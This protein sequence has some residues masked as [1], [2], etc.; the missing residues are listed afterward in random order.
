M[1]VLHKTIKQSF[2]GL[3]KIIVNAF[4]IFWSDVKGGIKNPLMMIILAGLVILPS[5]YAWVNILASTDPYSPEA[6]GGIRFAVANMDEGGSL[7]DKEMDL[8]SQIVDNLKENDKMGWTFYETREQ[9]VQSVIQG[10]S[11]AAVVIPENFSA[12]VCTMF[13]NPVKP[14][15]EYYVNMKTNAIAPKMTN[16]AV[17]TLQKTIKEQIIGEVVKTLYDAL[18]IVGGELD[19]NSDKIRKGLNMLYDSEDIITEIPGKVS[20]LRDQAQDALDEIQD[21]KSQANELISLL[22]NAQDLIVNLTAD[23]TELDKKL[24]EYEPRILQALKDVGAI[25]DEINDISQNILNIHNKIDNV[26]NKFEKLSNLIHS[27][28]EALL[29]GNSINGILKDIRNATSEISD[30]LSDLRTDLDDELFPKLHQYLDDTYDI[31]FDALAKINDGLDE[32]DAVMDLIDKAVNKGNE[33]L[34]HVDD[35][36]TEYPKYEEKLLDIIHKVK[37]L[38]ENIDINTV[39]DLLTANSDDESNFFSSPVTVTEKD[40]YPTATYGAAMTPFYTTLCL[41]VGAVILCA[42]LTTEAKNARFPF[43]RRQEYFGKWLL[44]V[45]LGLLQG[46]IVALGDIYLLNISVL[47]PVLFVLTIMYL[48]L[49]F[50]TIVYTLVFQFGN[51]GKA[52]AVILLV[53]QIAGSGGTFPIE[54]TPQFFQNIYAVLPFTYGINAMRETVAGIY[55]PNFIHDFKILNIYLTAFLV[56]GLISKHWIKKITIG[57]QKKMSESGLTE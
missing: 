10:E 9:A 2:H 54:C 1:I 31:S 49:L 16:S 51:V 41:W 38:D 28:E 30:L 23:I 45:V 20:G 56:F 4:R 42:L 5:L 34:G 33:A 14:N 32:I 37:K 12:N 44:F 52:I 40:F 35:F 43:T 6:T 57:A 3:I 46:L 21:K 22:E 17:Q 29:N 48:S 24:T 15:L 39:I 19:E 13:D 7:F 53:L 11:Y 36:L 55:Y 47:H 50:V 26:L 18:N 25:S 27:L 8:G